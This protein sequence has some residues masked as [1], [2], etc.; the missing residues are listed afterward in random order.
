MIQKKLIS[1]NK[2]ARYYCSGEKT[3]AVKN[4]WFLLHGYGEDALQFAQP[5][6]SF[7]AQG[8]F[9]IAVEGLSR[10]YRNGFYGGVGAS[11]MTSE[12]RM[13]DIADNMNYLK[14]VY[15]Q[16][17]N[18]FDASATIH[19]LGFSQGVATLARFIAT[20]QPKFHHLWICAGDIPKDLDWNEF[21]SAVQSAQVHIMIG[22]NDPFIT[23]EK[24]EEMQFFLASKKLNYQ[25]HQFDGKHEI[26]FSKLEEIRN[27]A[28]K[29]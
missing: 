13:S 19:L 11:W 18:S 10:F 6:Q 23:P 1:V 5:F 17:I 25:V 28:T 15:T 8:D 3:E 27:A 26:N 2:T 14:T 7:V 9:V 20:F 22:R 12:E 21:I 16:E 4:I 29:V 24:W